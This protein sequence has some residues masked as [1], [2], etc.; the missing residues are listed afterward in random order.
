M[1]EMKRRKRQSAYLLFVH[2]TN[3]DLIVMS[4][5]WIEWTI[6]RQEREREDGRYRIDQ[7]VFDQILIEMIRKI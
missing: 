7:N 5:V 2:R 3:K 6:G 4:H 1:I